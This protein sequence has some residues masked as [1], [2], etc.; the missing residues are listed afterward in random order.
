VNAAKKI[1]EESLKGAGAVEGKMV[2][3]AVARHARQVL[4]I[5]RALSLNV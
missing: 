1:I 5:A 4:S 3:E 2:D